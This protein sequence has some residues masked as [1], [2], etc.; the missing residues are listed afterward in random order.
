LLGALPDRVLIDT[1]VLR[2]LVWH[3]V[4]PGERRE[5]LRE[6]SEVQVMLSFLQGCSRRATTSHVAVELSRALLSLARR[7]QL[8]RARR[9]LFGPFWSAFEELAGCPVAALDLEV[10]AAVGLADAALLEVARAEELCLLTG[11]TELFG[12]ARRAGLP[13][14]SVWEITCHPLLAW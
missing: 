1:G 14:L 9:H 12:R 6:P 7:E 2:D 3:S 4:F 5:L 8:A 11:D 10:I 13:A